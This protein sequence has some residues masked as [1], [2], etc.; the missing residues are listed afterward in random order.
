MAKTK[1]LFKIKTIYYLRYKINGKLI[2]K[3]LSTS[4]QSEAIQKRNKILASV[5]DVRIEEDVVYKTARA[6]KI[7]TSKD[8]LLSKV[9]NS[10]ESNLKRDDASETAINSYKFSTDEF[11]TWVKSKYAEIKYINNISDEIA[12]TYSDY[13]INEQKIA[14]S[15][16]NKKITALQK[17]FKSIEK[18]TN[19]L[20]NP[21]R[22]ENIHRRTKRTISKKEFTKDEAIKI[23]NSFDEINVLNKN[24]LK[25]M[26]FIGIY[27]GLRMKDCCLLKWDSISFENDLITTIPH[28]TRR[29][30]TEVKIPIL[31]ELKEQLLEATDWR[32]D[33]YLLP[34]LAT[35]Y[36]KNREN[37]QKIVSKVIV[38]NGFKSSLSLGKIDI[39]RKLA[40]SQY[41]F[42]SF[43]YTFITIC[44]E[45]NIPISVVQSIVGHLTSKQTNDY[46]RFSSNYKQKMMNS[47]SL[48]NKINDKKRKL[49]EKLDDISDEKLERILKIL[50]E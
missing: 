38:H 50:G 41:G 40:P 3:S 43:R 31:L 45:N 49:L 11:L 42:H 8:I 47:F 37:I 17:L 20:F 18:E 10:F 1:N 4:I 46:I 22:S 26:F 48:G 44:A 21:F 25:V 39:Q 9:W 35:R 13:L 6:K 23:L 15:T 36:N 29:Y 28:K 5:R 7:Y 12:L 27:T 14:N 24:E 16:F 2:T 19:N 34:N 33:D 30:G 32:V